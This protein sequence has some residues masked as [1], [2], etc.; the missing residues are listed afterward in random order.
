M[1]TNKSRARQTRAIIALSCLVVAAL[2]WGLATAR[3]P[4]PPNQTSGSS[5]TAGGSGSAADSA[6]SVNAALREMRAA[7]VAD[8]ALLTLT[9]TV[10]KEPTCGCCSKWVEHMRA[11]GFKVVAEDR[12]NMD[13]VKKELGVHA[14]LQSCHTAKIGTYVIEGHVPAE[15]VMRLLR[16]NLAVAG[17]AAPGMPIGSPGME[18]SVAE[19]YNVLA[20]DKAGKT[21]IFAGH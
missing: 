3:T 10:Y 20:F 21:T 6:A 15:D 4:A 16:E 1:K 11:A 14:N 18:A 13:P 9:M 2:V 19:K 17:L 8:S 7:G 12:V 5:A